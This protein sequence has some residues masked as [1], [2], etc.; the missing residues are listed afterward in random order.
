MGHMNHSAFVFHILR[1]CPSM[2][3]SCRILHI[4]VH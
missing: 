4:Y 2:L 3:C 1:T